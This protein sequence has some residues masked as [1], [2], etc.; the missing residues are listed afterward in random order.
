M[1]HKIFKSLNLLIL[2]AFG[3]SFFNLRLLNAANIPSTEMLKKA[4]DIKKYT[5][6][7]LLL[8]Y[9]SIKVDVMPSGLSYFTTHKLYKVL[10]QKGAL[11][12]SVVKYGYDPLTA[13]ADIKKVIIYRNNGKIEEL[14]M[15]KEL[16]YPAPARA[17]YWG[18]RE[19]MIGVGRLQP[20]DGLE[21]I[22]YKKGF[23]YALLDN[24]DDQKYIPPMKGNFYDIVPFWSDDAAH[25]YIQTKVYSVK[26]PAE[27]KIQYK[28]YH[29]EIQTRQ[30][31][32]GNN[33]EY[34][35]TLKDI[36]PF[37]K[38]PYMVSLYDVAPKL[39]LSTAPDWQ[40][41]SRWFYKVNEDYGSFAST[42]EIKEKVNEIL[43]GAKD[44]IDSVSRLTHWAGD[45]VRY[46][47]LTMGC[48]EGYT[49]HKGSLTFRDRCG[50]CKDKAGMC[51]TL[52][53]AAGFEA[54]P[55]MTMAG[56]KIDEI[57]ADHFNHCVASVRLKDGNLHMLDPTWV[58]LRR[59]LWSSAEQ[60]QNYLIGTPNGNPLAETPLS[61]PEDH[62]VK[63]KNNSELNNN[64]NLSGELVIVAEGQSD[65]AVR[66]MFTY[67][68][69]TQWSDNVRKELLEVYPLA[70]IVSIDYG[71][72]YDYLGSPVTIKIKYSIPD[73]AVITDKDIIVK[74]LFASNLFS[75]AQAQLNYDTTLVDR[76]YAFRDR[77]SRLVEINDNI[78]MPNNT[79]IV[80]IP[81]EKNFKG[82]ASS[83]GADYFLKDKTLYFT[84]KATYY[85]RVYDSSD[86]TDF[87]KC[88]IAQLK[89]NSEKVILRKK[90]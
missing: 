41:K 34:T 86:W 39:L 37:V 81:S 26:L 35:F 66:S 3:I 64:G 83:F 5:D 89:T 57:P 79:D 61:P 1:N 53:R 46:S 56:S 29:G 38:E 17:I 6:N 49:L 77:C 75:R 11:D 70:Q 7:Q 43:K 87:R 60:Q 9:D 18:A 45:Q 4:G 14:D 78:K 65:A 69:M 68:Y 90:A 58:P 19:K 73:Y 82:K 72:P 80:Y 62:Y 67:Y 20:G 22:L 24:G 42:P 55:A 30:T 23:S 31:K 44:Q 51:I 59:E 32:A 48:G 28:F 63:I 47:G 54:Y 27:M 52:L 36:K 21:V 76:K 12:L 13:F 40:S 25:T 33:V 88:V 10:T 84:E 15:S 74:P 8:V 85:K 50:V 2:I 71:N 16:D